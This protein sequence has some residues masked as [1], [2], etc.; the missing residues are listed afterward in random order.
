[1]KVR[2]SFC[3]KQK[4]LIFVWLER[5][6][7]PFPDEACFAPTDVD[8]FESSGEGESGV[9]LEDVGVPETAVNIQDSEPVCGITCGKHGK[10]DCCG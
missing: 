2:S 6:G 3:L 4:P 8:D 9:G 1:V 5:E 10:R 7:E